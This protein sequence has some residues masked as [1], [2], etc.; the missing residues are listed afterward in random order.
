MQNYIFEPLGLK[1]I[2]MFPNE[3]MKA[4]LAHLQFRSQDGS[5]SP[6]DHI[7]RRP[8]IV[9]TEA[10]KKACLNSG[11]AGCFARPQEYCRKPEARYVVSI[12]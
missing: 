9:S 5:L 11:G 1:D 3:S 12:S 10:E 8:L 6:Y 4:R 7:H 2:S